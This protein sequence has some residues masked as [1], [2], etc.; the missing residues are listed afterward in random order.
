M[1]SYLVKELETIKKM[2]DSKKA[3]L[4]KVLSTTA[5]VVES[6]ELQDAHERR[7]A[8]A[9][10]F[11]DEL[12]EVRTVLSFANNVLLVNF[13]TLDRLS[14]KADFCNI[15]FDGEF[16]KLVIVQNFPYDDLWLLY[17]A[18]VEKI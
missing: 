10:V 9:E 5:P 6:E 13:E 18:A 1:K 11:L 17:V 14:K 3:R 7:Q 4:E 15:E 2:L 16:C 8:N 12:T